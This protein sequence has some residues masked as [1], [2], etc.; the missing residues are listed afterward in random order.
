MLDALLALVKAR[1]LMAAVRYDVI[2]CM[3]ERT[4]TAAEVAHER[5]LDP[6]SAFL[7]L[8]VLAFSG[9]VKQRGERFGL[10]ALGKRTLLDD[11]DGA[12]TQYLAW[13]YTQW[14][15]FDG[16]ESML[17][18]GTGLAVHD[19]MTDWQS[20]LGGM[21]EIA[22]A[23]APAIGRAVPVP[24]RAR[25][26]LDIAGAHGAF[27]A[28][29]AERHAGLSVKVLELPEAVPHAQALAAKH[30]LLV[31]HIACDALTD[32]LPSADVA[33]IAN[34]VHHLAE[35][36]ARRLVTRVRD[37]LTPGGTIAIWDL[38]QPS[39]T[40]Q[41][42]FTDAIALYFRLTSG[43][44]C[45]RADEMRSWLGDFEN[46]RFKRFARAP[47]YVLVTARRRRN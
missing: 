6:E 29:I 3:R 36:E 35:P 23:V 40:A 2:G 9:Y 13:N 5:G 46:V 1:S 39:P 43:S 33:M 37:A 47:G 4:R 42:D 26:L 8:R 38:E 28:A 7:L 14:D 27:G 22:R 21:Y 11:S 44:R 15:Y 25:T 12:C 10:T 34:F 17:E 41:A 45:Y 24:A 20:Y 16:F 19:A 18:T 32:T 30:G 31:E